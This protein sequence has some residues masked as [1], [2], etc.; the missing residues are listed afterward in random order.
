MR[1]SALSA[2]TTWYGKGVLRGDDPQFVTTTE[3]RKEM[4]AV[5]GSWVKYWAAESS[6]LNEIKWVKL[7]PL[8]DMTLEE[9]TADGYRQVSEST[10][11]LIVSEI[12]RLYFLATYDIR[13]HA[14]WSLAKTT[15]MWWISDWCELVI[16]PPCLDTSAPLEEMRQENDAKK[17]KETTDGPGAE[18]ED[19][20][21]EKVRETPNEKFQRVVNNLVVVTGE[22]EEEE[23]K[24]PPA[25]KDKLWYRPVYSYT[26]RNLYDAVMLLTERI[27][28]Y[29]VH[30]EIVTLIYRLT[31]RLGALLLA[32]GSEMVFDMPRYRTAIQ[33]D[34]Y[35]CNRAFLCWA[36]AY[37]YELLQRVHYLTYM[38]RRT[39]PVPEEEHTESRIKSLKEFILFLCRDM[40]H[41]DFMT[42]FRLSSEENYQFPGDNMYGRYL[43]PEGVLNRGDLLLELR[44]TR[45][46]VRFFGNERLDEQTILTGIMYG[47]THLY[48]LCL[49]NI[50]DRYFHVECDMRWRDGSVVDQ[51]GIGLSQHKLIDSDSPCIVS[52]FS[53]PVLHHKLAILGTDDI[54]QTL[55]AWLLFIR[56]HKGGMC[57]HTNI[58]KQIN[59]LLGEDATMQQVVTRNATQAQASE[60]ERVFSEDQTSVI[61]P[62]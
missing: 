10:A 54:Y 60:P 48:R 57:H 41:A 50:L 27:N 44:P 24:R 29:P 26:Q 51:S 47:E 35:M 32:P 38:S 58:S 28:D 19:D 1:L 25:S 11:M 3:C 40:G 30:E 34:M 12:S 21:D 46:A 59:Q 17:R 7:A 5:F 16:N 31:G 22:E 20:D 14:A 53:R 37:Y 36:S 6:Y 2:W 39:L 8:P 45:Q 15:C 49:L 62:L 56:R 33:E 9:L 61:K 52:I 55:V 42:L 43:H 4:L 23:E 18:D 13:E